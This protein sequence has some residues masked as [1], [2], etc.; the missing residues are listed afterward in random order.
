MLPDPTIRVLIV[1]ADKAV[2]DFIIKELAWV[3]CVYQCECA[4][5]G[6]E[7]LA[8]LERNQE[9]HLV[10]CEFKLKGMNGFRLL[11]LV[12]ATHPDTQI[13]FA[14]SV[15]DVSAAMWAIREG[16]SDYLLKPLTVKEL[17]TAVRTA[18]AKQKFVTATREYQNQLESM[19]ASL[20]EQVQ[21]LQLRAVPESV[22][23]N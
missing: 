16:A 8:L 3:S 2:R 13:M 18:I 22:K 19:V 4:D 5:S 9:I 10:I 17:L 7:A 21:V 6:E 12:K 11:Q 14:T 1:D 15:K 23:P 20:Q